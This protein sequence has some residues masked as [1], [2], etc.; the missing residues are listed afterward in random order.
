LSG[1]FRHCS[2]KGSITMAVTAGGEAY[3]KTRDASSGRAQGLP[4]QASEEFITALC[5]DFELH[6]EAVMVRKTRSA[7]YLK[8]VAALV[9]K[10]FSVKSGS[11]DGWRVQVHVDGDTV[12]ILSRQGSQLRRA[13]A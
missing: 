8:I 7:D 5:E 13:V 12:P 1:D 10:E 9:P 2:D 11:L 6:S 3:L 4:Q